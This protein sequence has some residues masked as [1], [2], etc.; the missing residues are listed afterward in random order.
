MNKAEKERRDKKDFILTAVLPLCFFPISL[1]ILIAL[2]MEK[3][4]FMRWPAPG[5]FLLL[6]DYLAFIGWFC[7]T[8]EKTPKA[9]GPRRKPWD[10][11]ARHGM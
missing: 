11:E 1:I 2:M 7:W 5:A 9:P 8:S 3:A 10:K 6:I 4:S